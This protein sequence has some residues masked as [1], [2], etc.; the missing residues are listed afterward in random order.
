M[1]KEI[2]LLKVDDMFNMHVISQDV[3]DNAPPPASRTSNEL[4]IFSCKTCEKVVKTL[5]HMRL[6]CLSHTTLKPFKCTKC[7]YASNSKGE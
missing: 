3:N 6:H 5:S 1:L 7:N 2:F 4:T